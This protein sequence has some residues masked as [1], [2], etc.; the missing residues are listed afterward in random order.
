MNSKKYL[1]LSIFNKIVLLI[2]LFTLSSCSTVLVYQAGSHGGLTEG[3]Q[4]GT[5][6]SEGKRI[7]TFF[8]GAM[9]QDVIIKDCREGDGD[10]LNIEEIRIEKNFGSIFASVITLGLWEPMKISWKCAKPEGPTGELD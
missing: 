4:P 6:W 9:R 1:S 3:N 5:E 7:N 8:W 10:R 2:F